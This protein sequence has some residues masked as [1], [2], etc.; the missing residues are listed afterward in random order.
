MKIEAAKT[1]SG[2]DLNAGEF[3]FV[4]LDANRATVAKG[5]NVAAGKDQPGKIVF[6]GINYTTAKI[7]QALAD[8]TATR[9]PDG[10]YRFE[11]TVAEQTTPLPE[12]VTGSVF[13][14]QIEVVVTDNGDGTLSP[15]V[16][17]PAGSNSWRSKT[18]MT[19]IRW[20]WSSGAP[21]G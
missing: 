7:E 14:F 19:R 15:E 12:G 11:Y 9:D 3:N 4:V 5:S 6:T 18:R 10:T 17:Y 1:L 21:S 8:G 20:A 2:R 13:T 16:T